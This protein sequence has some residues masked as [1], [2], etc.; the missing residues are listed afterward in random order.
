MTRTTHGAGL[1]IVQY[2]GFTVHSLATEN[3]F[4]GQLCAVN[5]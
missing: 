2:F 4:Q 5:S 1:M 3:T